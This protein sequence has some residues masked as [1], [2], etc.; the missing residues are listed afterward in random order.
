MDGH[1]P[2]ALREYVQVFGRPSIVNVVG[3]HIIG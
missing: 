1:S 3:D 2:V